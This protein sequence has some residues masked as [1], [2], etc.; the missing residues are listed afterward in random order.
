MCRIL[1]LQENAEKKK[2][3]KQQH[4]TAVVDKTDDMGMESL[5]TSPMHTTTNSLSP[6][7]TETI[8]IHSPTVITSSSSSASSTE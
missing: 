2:Q 1:K 7:M 4:S 8:T 5:P 3:L 6:A